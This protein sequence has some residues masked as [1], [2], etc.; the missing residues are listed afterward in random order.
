[1]VDLLY[2]NI[3]LHFILNVPKDCPNHER[4]IQPFKMNSLF[5]GLNPL[6]LHFCCLNLFFGIVTA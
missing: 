5:V 4:G 3:F 1:M 6:S 2:K